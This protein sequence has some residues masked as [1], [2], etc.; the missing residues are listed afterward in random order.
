MKG[1][2]QALR[3]EKMESKET[4]LCDYPWAI[5][6]CV[7]HI[8]GDSECQNFS[9]HSGYGR[10]LLVLIAMATVV[11]MLYGKTTSAVL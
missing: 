1:L 2:L 4:G 5:E 6:L 9:T 10:F 8:V 3:T 11:V 7:I